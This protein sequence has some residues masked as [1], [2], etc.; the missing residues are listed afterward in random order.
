MHAGGLAA[1]GTV[2]ELK[3]VFAGAAVLEVSCP[4]LLDALEP[5]EREG[6]A[7]EVA[8]FGTRLHLVV[9]DA[10]EGRRRVL[11]I[12]G[13]QKNEPAAVERIVPSL[14]DVFIHY[15]RSREPAA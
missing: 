9:R 11:E 15:I 8:V 3:E 7:M 12:L 13:R 1:L 14:E 6:I 2:S 10:E 5:I 4:R